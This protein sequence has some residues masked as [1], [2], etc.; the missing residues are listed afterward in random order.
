MFVQAFGT[1]KIPEHSFGTQN[2]LQK[3]KMSISHHFFLLVIPFLNIGNSWPHWLSVY[4][5][6][7]S[8][9]NHFHVK[10]STNPQ[11][12]QQQ[13]FP[14]VLFNGPKLLIS[15]VLFSFGSA[16]HFIPFVLESSCHMIHLSPGNC[17]PA[18]SPIGVNHFSK[19]PPRVLVCKSGQ[20]DRPG[21]FVFETFVCARMLHPSKAPRLTARSGPLPPSRNKMSPNKCPESPISTI[22]CTEFHHIPLATSTQLHLSIFS[23]VLSLQNLPVHTT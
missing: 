1:L 21:S 13:L 4:R 7:F 14:F 23:F 11:Y 9:G 10:W 16:N 8:A 20:S 19:P 5:R 3:M 15:I 18:P 17:S 6:Q 2:T 12:L 22:Y